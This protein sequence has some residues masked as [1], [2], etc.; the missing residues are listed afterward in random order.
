MRITNNKLNYNIINRIMKPKITIANNK[1]EN[2]IINNITNVE[3]D[4]LLYL[5]LRQNSI[6][7]IKGLYYKDVMLKL[8]IKSKQTFYNALYNLEKKEYIKIN[9]SNRTQYWECTIL[10][11]IFNNEVDDSN[12]YFNT[13]RKFLFSTTFQK[14]ALNEKKLCIKLSIIYQQDNCNKFGLYLYP[15]T[16][17]K[18]L[19]IK[20]KNIIYKYMKNISKIFP[21]VIK[22]GIQDNLFFLTENNTVPFETN[23]CT[24]KENYLHH[25]LTHFCKLFKISY[26]L[27]DIKDLTILIL[28]YFKYGY[29][30]I[31]N[32]IINNLLSKKCI[33]PKLLNY[34]LH[35]KLVYNE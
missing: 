18:W 11:N 1:N 23:N 15:N 4:L 32:I 16:I 7:M 17:Q 25:K 13:N 29:G 2:I 28:Q 12:G 24:E 19:G 10:N 31:S 14:L 6:G 20:S 22:Q 27:K 34:L 26:S 30:T 9:Y 3:L 21:N 35:N 5:S 8:H 33:Q